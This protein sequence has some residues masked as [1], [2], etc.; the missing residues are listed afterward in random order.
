M[1]SLES[2]VEGGGGVGLIGMRERVQALSGTLS[3]SDR[4]PDRGTEVRCRLPLSPAEAEGISAKVSSRV[5]SAWSIATK[6]ERFTSLI[7]QHFDFARRKVDPQGR[8]VFRFLRR[9]PVGIERR[10][11]DFVAFV[12]EEGPRFDAEQVLRL[13][14]FAAFEELEVVE[15]V[16]HRG[17]ACR[18]TRN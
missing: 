7:D 9:L 8:P 15:D 2:K 16:V 11:A 12:V 17:C 18:S 4:S 6:I 14:Q 5:K 13:G 10:R 1:A 3:I